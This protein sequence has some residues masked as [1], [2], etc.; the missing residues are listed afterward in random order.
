MTEKSI[1]QRHKLLTWKVTQFLIHE[2]NRLWENKIPEEK[3]RKL[4]IKTTQELNKVIC[5]Y[6]GSGKTLKQNEIE[7]QTTKYLKEI[8]EEALVAIAK[9]K[10]TKRKEKADID[11]ILAHIIYE[12]N[13]FGYCWYNNGQI[14]TELGRLEQRTRIR[15]ILKQMERDGMT[16]KVKIKKNGFRQNTDYYRLRFT[17]SEEDANKWAGMYKP[18]Q[19]PNK[20]TILENFALKG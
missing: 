4:L 5:F 7:E 14:A 3:F 13:Y 20:E 11:L 15:E 18:E 10:N 2:H 6:D 8:T 17:L 1:Y 9:D 19:E 16:I 12:W